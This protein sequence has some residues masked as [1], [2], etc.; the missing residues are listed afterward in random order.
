MARFKELAELPTHVREVLDVQLQEVWMDAFNPAFAASNSLLEAYN[1]AWSKV[2]SEAFHGEADLNQIVPDGTKE[3]QRL[4]EAGMPFSDHAVGYWIETSSIELNE[5]EPSWIQALPLGKYTHPVYG[6][7]NV[8][9]EK[10]QRMAA[11]IASNVRG[12]ELDIDYDHKDKSG[13]AAGWVKN[14]EARPDGL[15]IA[16]EWTQKAYNLLKDKAY[17]YFS[18]EFVDNWTHPKT[19]QKHQDVLFGGALTNRPFLKDIL[20]INL[21]EVI[22]SGG[23]MNEEIKKLLGL[24]DG[25]TDEEIMAALTAKLETPTPDPQADPDPNA[26]P[27]GEPPVADPQDE[28]EKEPALA[29]LSEL[30]TQ[31]VQLAERIVQLEAEN[32]KQEVA[33]K[34]SEVTDNAVIAPA[35]TQKLSEAVLAAPK[36]LGDKIIDLFKDMSKS[37]VSLSENGRGHTAEESTAVKS[38][39]EKVAAYQKAHETDYVTALSDVAAEFPQLYNEYRDESYIKEGAK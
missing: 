22:P 8:T 16:V 25:A 14:S 32:R 17:K 28:P 30:S 26:D 1:T 29:Q 27:N 33:A 6:T 38:F 31:N 24:S 7:I 4:M 11:N 15:W 9:P 39:N 10:V 36:E 5:G 20:P 23:N 2:F 34:L 18:P 35:M 37:V 12:T 3:T 19:S 21:S 13:E